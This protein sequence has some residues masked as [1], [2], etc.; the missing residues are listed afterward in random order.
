M[1]YASDLFPFESRWAKI[2]GQKIHYVDEG[3]GDTILISHA[4][5][6][7]SFMYRRFIQLLS[8]RYRC[9]A[10]DYPGF[11]LSQNISGAPCNIQSQADLLDL[12]ITHLQLNELIGLGHDTGG[13]SISAVA[14]IKPHLFRGLILTDTLVFPTREYPKI[15]R[16]LSIMGTHLFRAINAQSNLLVRLT[17]NK[18]VVT[19]KL[20]KREKQQYLNLFN[21]KEKR[22][23]ITE[24]LYSLRQSHELMRKVK[25]AFAAELNQKK[26]LLIYGEQDPVTKL[27][28]PVRMQKML[29]QSELHFISKE[30]HFPHEGQ[31]E[32]MCEI[33]DLW[34]RTHMVEA[35]GG[36]LP[37]FELKSI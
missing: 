11:G 36:D 34:M 16:L 15:H 28:I 30:G 8:R 14:A 23:R 25:N 22:N 17:I 2:R 21:S 6:G 4:A 12:F 10:L 32:R 27:E 1:E 37:A 13:P 18:G 33:I 35:D 29:P 20:Q 3:Q 9:V 7:S 31:P 26:I 19:R 24:V 5:L